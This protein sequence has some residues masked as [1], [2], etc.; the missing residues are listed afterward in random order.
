MS[1]VMATGHHDTPAEGQQP[2]FF[3]A[4]FLAKEPSQPQGRSGKPKPSF[5]SLFE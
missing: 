3:W 5:L 2:L 1:H 4:E